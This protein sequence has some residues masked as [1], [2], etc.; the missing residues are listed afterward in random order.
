M[1]ADPTEE[2]SWFTL[3]RFAMLLGALVAVSFGDVFLGFG[4]FALGDFDVFGY[5]LAYHC[6]ESLLRGELPLWNPLNNFGLPFLAQWNTM[7][8]YP[9]ALIHLVLPLSWSLGVFCVLHLYLGGLGM[10]QLAT[11]WTG[12]GPGAAVAGVTYAFSGLTQSALMWPNNSAAL[13]LLPWVV[14]SVDAGCRYG[15]RPLLTAVFVGS[16]QMLT[17]APE[18]I[19]FTWILAALRLA[20]MAGPVGA[21]LRSWKRFGFQIALI[22]TLCAVQLLPFL[23]LLAHSQRGAA[24]QNVWSAGPLVFGNYFVPLF[25]TL[26][27]SAGTFYQADQFWVVSSYAGI[28]T[29]LLAAVAVLGDRRREVRLLACAGAAALLLAIGG[30][31][32]PLGMMRYPAKFLVPVALV[33]P[34]LAAFGMAAI[35]RPDETLAIW[36]R[37]LALT[38]GGWA[39]TMI[40]IRALPIVG[41]GNGLATMNGLTRLAW[42]LAAGGILFAMLRRPEAK[43]HN[44]LAMAV[45]LVLW[46]DL[47]TQQPHLAPRIERAA[48]D[49]KIPLQPELPRP[50]AGR[51]ML[52]ANALSELKGKTLPDLGQ[53]T[54][55]HRLSL[56]DN[57]NLREGVAK[58][59]GLYSLYLK[60]QQEVEHLLYAGPHELR[61]PLANFVGISHHS[62][63]TN[64]FQWSRRGPAMPLVSAGQS[65]KY[66]DA[67]GTLQA[68]A[69][70]AFDPV[71]VVCL[72][73][74]F[75][76]AVGEVGT[77]A[78]ISA[79]TISE[80]EWTFSVAAE[81]EALVVISQAHY[82]PW[83][84]EVNGRPVE[85][86][87]ANHA[88][89]AIK[90]PSGENKIRLR[91]HDR[92]FQTGSL[93]SLI[94]LAGLLIAGWRVRNRATPPAT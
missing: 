84:A 4:T 73:P 11:R 75:A 13:G 5:P 64:I 44:W 83:Q 33:L 38:L 82:H 19:L 54:V 18:I 93:I 17:G 23:D 60:E 12:S 53:T 80:H 46:L 29:L 68:L 52:T 59:D 56:F 78:T 20:F 43:R 3:P 50:D 36:K 9:P 74:D 47:K 8:L 10:F 41:E 71:R 27:S 6:R 66:A 76:D 85:I 25:R 31:L 39:I 63:P 57:L 77:N 55:L 15:G 72:D 62:S 26:Q 86:W 48:Y 1:P 24:G 67:R 32:V 69:D 88:F 91:Y 49:Q 89:Q 34:L 94:A 90:V 61:G 81:K 45:L 58:V 51:V 16:L 7:V 42:L 2:P 65:P 30:K 35:K 40:L 22:S 87:R 21:S 28:G 70:E 37:G 92:A 14:L 79:V